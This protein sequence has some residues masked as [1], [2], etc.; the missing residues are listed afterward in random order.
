MGGSDPSGA[1]FSSGRKSKGLFN[2][3]FTKFHRRTQ[4]QWRPG[5]S[6]APCPGARRPTSHIPIHEA[7]VAFQPRD[8]GRREKAGLRV[9]LTLWAREMTARRRAP[10]EGARN[11]KGGDTSPPWPARPPVNGHLFDARFRRHVAHLVRLGPRPV[12]ECLLQLVGTGAIDRTALVM[13][14]EQYQRLDVDAVAALGGDRW[15]EST[16]AVNTA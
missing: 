14:L 4:E 9:F 5:A 1:E 6:Q 12:G 13:V 8:L 10:C 11:S 2:V 3:R 7:P 16:F 15:P